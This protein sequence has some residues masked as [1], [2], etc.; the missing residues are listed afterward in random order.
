MLLWL[1]VGF[2]Q[3][4]GA[5]KVKNNLC[6]SYAAFSLCGIIDEP[7]DVIAKTAGLSA[8][9][10][11]MLIARRLIDPT[12]IIVYSSKT[13][14][15]QL[16]D[17]WRRIL[18]VILPRRRHLL[19]LWTWLESASS[20]CVICNCVRHLASQSNQCHLVGALL[21]CR[22]LVLTLKFPEL[23]PKRIHYS[24]HSTPFEHIFD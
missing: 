8:P 3:T 17:A 5:Y 24:Q 13:S 16:N 11:H 19:R 18:R 9:A 23:E 20:V 4:L 6:Y 22:Y 2:A 14:H 7:A 21:Y 10:T 1:F 12:T 15:V